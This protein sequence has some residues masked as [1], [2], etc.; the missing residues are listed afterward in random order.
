M[1][2][3]NKQDQVAVRRDDVGKNRLKLES[4][5]QLMMRGIVIGDY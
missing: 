4:F 1:V 3:W 2:F 5:E